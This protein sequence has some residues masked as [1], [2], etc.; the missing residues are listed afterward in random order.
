MK[1]FLSV[2]LAGVVMTGLAYAG[3]FQPTPARKNWEGRFFT[4]QKGYLQVYA[5]RGARS[6]APENVI[7]SYATALRIGTDFVDMDIVVTKDHQLIVYHDLYLNPDILRDENSR[8]IG[9]FKSK[10]ELFA[11]VRGKG[12]EA[13]KPYLVYS[14]TLAEMRKYDAGCL[15]PDAP[16][17]RFFPDQMPLDGIRIPTLT[18]VIRYV[19]RHAG[20]NVGFQIEFKTDP[21]H[22]DW[23]PPPR[24]FAELLHKALKEEGILYRS[25]VQSF[26]WR[27][28]YELNKIDPMIHTAFLTQIEIDDPTECHYR[29]EDRRWNE[30]WCGEGRSFH[31]YG[32]SIPRM[33]KALG[34]YC[35]EPQDIELTRED[36]D[37]AH[38]LGLKVV[39]WTWPEVSGV[40]FDPERIALLME[41][42][43]DG[44]IT[45]DPARLIG[46]MAAHGMPLPPRHEIPATSNVAERL[47][48][49][50]SPR[51]A[52]GL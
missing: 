50:F 52:G 3:D 37:E 30:R 46:I 25:E 32:H 44:I 33:V 42:G 24:V 41:W 22:K 48:R 38:K 5:H 1:R 17:A 4:P 51:P 13:M 20:D 47:K 40:A 34:G 18:E 21:N 12:A 10:K 7:S 8:F 29:A 49:K 15:N 19:K 35:W 39:V 2:C 43:V 28:L 6:Y 27:C 26:D 16:Y 14:H 36:L 31:D 11:S 45:D 23:S 9:G